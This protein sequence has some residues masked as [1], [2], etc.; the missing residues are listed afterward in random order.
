VA[1][2]RYAPQ[3]TDGA[4]RVERFSYV[5]DSVAAAGTRIRTRL[6]RGR[7]TSLD[8]TDEPRS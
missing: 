7:I 4:T 2:R 3:A 8:I 1:A 6:S 5:H